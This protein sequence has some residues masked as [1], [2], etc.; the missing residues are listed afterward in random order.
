MKFDLKLEELL[1]K[2]NLRSQYDEDTY[3]EYIIKSRLVQFA[4]DYKKIVLWGGGQHTEQL[5][6]LIQSDIDI[7]YIVDND[8]MIQGKS[9]GGR[10]IKAP[11]AL[12][13]DQPDL[14][15]ISSHMYRREIAKNVEEMELGVKYIDVYSFYKDIDSFSGAPFYL[16]KVHNN[17]F[18]LR[19]LY[20]KETDKRRKEGFLLELI[21]Q[22]IKIRDF[23]YTEK[24]IG[25]YKT[26]YPN[27]SEFLDNFFCELKELFC[28]IKIRLKERDKKDVTMILVDALRAKDIFSTEEHM[29]FI[30]NKSKTSAVFKNAF[31]T[32]NYTYW[33]VASMLTGQLLFQANNYESTFTSFDKSVFLKWLQ[34]N[35]YKMYS[36]TNIDFFNQDNR[37]IQMGEKED[38]QSF[39]YISEPTSKVLWKYICN[40]AESTD[41]V[42]SLLHLPDIHEPYMCGFHRSRGV[43][44]SP[45]YYYYQKLENPEFTEKLANIQHKECLSYVD[46]QLEFYLDYV[47]K[48]ALV[49]LFGDH[50]QPVAGDQGAYSGCLTWYD[51]VM[52]VP[53]IVFGGGVE[54]NTVHGLI[55]LKDTS[56]L[57]LNF[58][59]NNKIE[60]IHNEFVIMERDPIYGERILKQ[61]HFI[62]L[63]GYKFIKGYRV[64]RG[65]LD[66]YVLY[67]DGV[68]EYYVLPDETNNLINESKYK[69]RI[70]EMSQEARKE[71]FP[72]FNTEKYQLNRK[73]LKDKGYHLE[74][75][76][77]GGR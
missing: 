62:E 29:P 41:K 16:Y 12:L 77:D 15:I 46:Q 71:S 11:N 58:L 73:I 42:Y 34:D 1:N 24:Y 31:C 13:E 47:S 30:L 60:E 39:R 33:S 23:V 74:V 54:P 52:H 35:D 48:E 38:R 59:K 3:I 2:Y 61:E 22:Y 72:N 36:F 32:S 49:V 37:V 51:D 20:E 4:R 26:S 45:L 55:S 56:H 18:V 6:K 9:L 27:K 76:S 10:I 14:L 68:E 5:L 69:A 64:V 53:L 17:L 19:K 21:I 44:V 67:D 57:I 63:A 40:L 50:G 28:L 43:I 7:K 70:K 25:E 75:Q 65:K 66:K 8:P